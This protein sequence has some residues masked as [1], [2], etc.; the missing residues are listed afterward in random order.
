MMSVLKKRRVSVEKQIKTVDRKLNRPWPI[1]WIAFNRRDVCDVTSTRSIVDVGIKGERQTSF[2]IS[3]GVLLITV[4]STL[5]HIF[6][7]Y[8]SISEFNSLWLKVSKVVNFWTNLVWKYKSLVTKAFICL[9]YSRCFR[10]HVD[11]GIYCY[12][13]RLSGL[14]Q[15]SINAIVWFL[16]SS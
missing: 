14:R 7:L 13:G 3:R 16:R 5:R 12:V 4:T 11:V 10:G 6:V 15:G 9:I 1:R 2:I 8:Q